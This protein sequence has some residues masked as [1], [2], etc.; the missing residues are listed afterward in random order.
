MP[1]KQRES[2]RIESKSNQVSMK[3][4][5][6]SQEILRGHYTYAEESAHEA[7]GIIDEIR[8]KLEIGLSSSSE[9]NFELL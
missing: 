8:Q 4:Q 9:N 7:S 2:E 3:I 6:K 5:Q 1:P